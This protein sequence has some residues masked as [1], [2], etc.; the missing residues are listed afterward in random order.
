MPK[1]SGKK[2]DKI[3]MAA[4]FETT[5]VNFKILW[6]FE[7]TTITKKSCTYVWQDSKFVEKKNGKQL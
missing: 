7:D 1:L 5:V 2:R 4:T 3:S 6:R